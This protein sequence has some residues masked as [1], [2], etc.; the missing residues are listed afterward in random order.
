MRNLSARSDLRALGT[1][2]R[3]GIEMSLTCEPHTLVLVTV[4]MR[5]MSV[6]G[7]QWGRL[8]H[9][10]WSSSLRNQTVGSPNVATISA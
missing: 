2:G 8:P 5:R 1:V 10:A 9:V 7:N 3:R 4:V 6:S